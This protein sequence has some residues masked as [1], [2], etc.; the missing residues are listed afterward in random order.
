MATRKYLDK[1]GLKEITTTQWTPDMKA[2]LRKACEQAVGFCLIEQHGIFLSLDD[3]D[4]NFV[5][6]EGHD[7]II[8]C[9][10]KTTDEIYNTVE[11][12]HKNNHTYPVVAACTTDTTDSPFDGHITLIPQ[13]C[14]NTFTNQA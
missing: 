13:S 8:D 6:D 5:K 7:N 11:T 4:F 10:G 12:W 14:R 9:S 1:T 2:N 3:N